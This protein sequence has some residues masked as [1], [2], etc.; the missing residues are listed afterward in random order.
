MGP[1]PEGLASYT[2]S[3]GAYVMAYA[4]LGHEGTELITGDLVTKI[5]EAH[6]VTGVQ[7]ALRWIY[8]HN[9]TLTT[10]AASVKHL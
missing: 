7:V 4:P 8:Q 5:G 3:K 6:N 2:K 10:K 9:V 1:N